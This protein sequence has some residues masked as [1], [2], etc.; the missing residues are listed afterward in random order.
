MMLATQTITAA[1]N[2]TGSTAINPATNVR[3]GARKRL[4]MP[5]NLDQDQRYKMVG[6]FESGTKLSL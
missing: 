6:Q 5:E 2:T 4:F 1:V 3:I